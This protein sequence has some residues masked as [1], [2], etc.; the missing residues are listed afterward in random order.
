[1][2]TN[3]LLQCNA[4]PFFSL[5]AKSS[6]IF[7]KLKVGKKNSQILDALRQIHL[8]IQNMVKNSDSVLQHKAAEN[9]K[10]A[11]NELL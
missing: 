9:L 6:S 10:E 11:D 7:E 8:N 1:M 3:T 2:K 4:R 5:R